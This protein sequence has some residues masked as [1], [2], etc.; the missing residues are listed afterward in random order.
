[1]VLVLPD[2]EATME[3][4]QNSVPFS[5]IKERQSFLMKSIQNSIGNVILAT[6]LG[7]L[8]VTAFDNP[9]EVHAADRPNILFIFSDDHAQAAISAYGSKVNQTPNIDRLAKDGARF[10][11]SF[12]TNSICTPSRATL[13]TGQYSHLN[14]VPVFNT[15]DGSRDHLGKRLQASGYHTGMIGKWHLGTDP[16]GF[17]RWIVLPGQGAYHNPMFI[18]PKGKC[19]IEGHCTQVTTDLGLEFLET[20][21][22]DKPFFLMLHQKAPHRAWEPDEKNKQ[23]FAN[24]S[25]VEPSTLFDAYATRPAALPENEQTVARDL[26][27]RDLKL[28]PPATL[29]ENKRGAWLNEKPTQLEVDGKLLEGEA[30]VKYK[31]Q[32]YMQ[33]YL[34]C[35][36]GVDDSVGQV[37]DYLDK[38]KLS[39]NTV[40][41][42][43]ADNGWYLG[44]LGLYDKRFMY[45]PGLRTPLIAR[46]PGIKNGIVPESMVANIDLAPTMLD[47]AGVS[48]PDSM[49]G[50]SFKPLLAG[51]TPREWRKSVYYRY[52][53]SPG[54]HNTQAHLGV[55][56]A[57][58]KLIY[59]WNKSTY[60]LYDLV[61]DPSEQNNLLFHD[62]SKNDTQL[63][64]IFSQL[65]SEITR[66]Q[67]EFRDD[68]QYASQAD[69]PKGGVDGPFDKPTPLGKKTV[70]EAIQLL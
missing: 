61:K 32:R 70:R 13:L 35:V 4:I 48:I 29:P 69:W 47:I 68:N 37:L 26:T 43:T 10:A 54:H 50:K 49:Q 57:T 53:H 31:Y 44:E 1:V 41:I 30:L 58:H 27:R 12:V 62:S 20:R 33:D 14:G 15:F 21:P 60:E 36:Q 52:Y 16:T 11:N 34:A 3:R 18:T 45:E 64:E 55:R 6:S 24:Q 8:L 5:L 28:T 38:N 22:K 40:V 9:P 46:G 51:E 25:F 23:K 67:K 17:D 42:Y 65:K 63:Q 7:A 39:E 66:L 59:Y 56:T 2:M 19:T